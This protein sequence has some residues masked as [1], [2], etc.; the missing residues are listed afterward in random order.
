MIKNH[1]IIEDESERIDEIKKVFIDFNN[2][3]SI[4]Q[5][6]YSN[7][8]PEGISEVTIYTKNA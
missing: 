2:I 5:K 7:E 4:Q 6:I 3:K 1:C 8:C